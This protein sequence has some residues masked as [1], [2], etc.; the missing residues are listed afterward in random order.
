VLLGERDRAA[1][2]MRWLASDDELGNAWAALGCDL[3]MP[4]ERVYDG[5]SLRDLTRLGRAGAGR[6]SLLWLEAREEAD[7]AGGTR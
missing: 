3:G 2:H 1:E 4:E 7:D 5:M 6:L